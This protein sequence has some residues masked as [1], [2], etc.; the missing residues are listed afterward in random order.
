VVGG[1]LGLGRTLRRRLE[2]K[3]RML[4]GVGVTLPDMDGNVAAPVSGPGAP[5]LSRL[6]DCEGRMWGLYRCGPWATPVGGR[7]AREGC[8][9][10][11]DSDG[12]DPP[13][14]GGG[15]G[16]A[17]EEGGYFGRSGAAAGGWGRAAG[18]G[19]GMTEVLAM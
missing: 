19:S 4:A 17:A 8:D 10:L 15:G 13:G 1:R 16:G 6:T 11:S 9:T 5:W 18:R 14:P 7:P 3:R 12:D 2:A